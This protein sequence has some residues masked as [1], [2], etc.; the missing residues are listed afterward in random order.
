MRRPPRPVTNQVN[1]QLRIGSVFRFDASLRSLA[2]CSMPV[3]AIGKLLNASRAK[4]SASLVPLVGCLRGR[5]LSKESC[6]GASSRDPVEVQLSVKPVSSF[7]CLFCSY[8]FC[9][10]LF[11]SYLFCS[12]LFCSYLF[13][14]ISSAPVS[15][16]P[17]SSVAFCSMS[18]SIFE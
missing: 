5:A 18:S 1:F 11:C 16:A 17:V 2:F 10:Y 7:P 8:L 15:S 4:D 14:S 6:V 13:C 3:V 9:S 12:Y